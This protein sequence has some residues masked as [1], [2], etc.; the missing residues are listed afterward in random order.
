MTEKLYGW[1]AEMSL[2]WKY[3][4]NELICYETGEILIKVDTHL[5]SGMISFNSAKSATGKVST[6]V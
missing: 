5:R 4:S 2:F 6:V 1:D 3:H